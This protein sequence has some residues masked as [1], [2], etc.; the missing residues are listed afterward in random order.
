M[1]R[2]DGELR[3]VDLPSLDHSTVRALVHDIMDDR[4]RRAYEGLLEVGFS[5]EIEGV[6]RFRANVFHHRQGAAA[7]FRSVPLQVPTLDEL[8]APR[9]FEE[10][11]T[12]SRGLVLATLHTGS[13]AK[14]VDRIIDVFPAGEKGTARSLLPERRHCS[15]NPKWGPSD[16][17]CKKIRR[18]PRSSAARVRPASVP[19][20]TPRGAHAPDSDETHDPTPT[21][22]SSHSARRLRSLAF[23]CSSSESLGAVISQVLLKKVGGGRIAAYEIM[24]ATSGHS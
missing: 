4:Q 15:R 5:F 1:I 6:T 3:P 10:I 21:R 14:A 20:R 16:F 19:A 12:A 17:G 8:G 23:L 11:V 24:V 18:R 7:V 22:E 9:I 13:A 2:V